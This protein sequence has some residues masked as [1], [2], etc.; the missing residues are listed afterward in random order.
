MDVGP[1]AAP[2]MAIDAASFSS[3]PT[4]AAKLK[5]K[6][7]PNW[8]AAPKNN[9]FGLVIKGVKS[10]IAPIPINSNNG[11]SSLEMPAL[12][13]TS[14]IPISF[15]PSITWVTAPEKGKFTNMVPKPIGNKRVAPYPF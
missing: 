8:A 3:N 10:I 1:S 7:I 12:N 14:I 13:N 11:N 4:K 5:V 2:I 9:I 15:T 6:K